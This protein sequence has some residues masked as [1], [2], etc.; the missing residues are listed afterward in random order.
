MAGE[1]YF[2]AETQYTAATSPD[3]EPEASYDAGDWN[4]QIVDH[5][6]DV[7]VLCSNKEMRDRILAF[8]N[9]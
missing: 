6:D 7:Q 9:Q 2:G 4:F 1:K 3:I 8:L 5:A